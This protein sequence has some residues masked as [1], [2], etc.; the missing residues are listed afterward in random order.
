MFEI[1]IYQNPQE[2]KINFE[3]FENLRKEINERLL[4]YKNQNYNNLKYAKDDKSKL[5]NFLKL[6]EERRK[7]IKN[8]I[9]KPYE[10]FEKLYNI[11]KNDIV[12]VIEKID[13]FI[14]NVEEKEKNEKMQKIKEYFYSKISENINFEKAFNQ[15]WLNKTYPLQ[16]IYKEIDALDQKIANDYLIINNMLSKYGVNENLYQNFIDHYDKT[17]DLN[18]VINEI[19]KYVDLRQKEKSDDKQNK[20]NY[21]ST[22][23]T[24]TNKNYNELFEV[25]LKIKGEK[26]KMLELKKFLEANDFCYEVIKQEK[27]K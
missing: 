25:T 21:I 20:T 1:K 6:L 13:E 22:T 10:E 2:V 4:I 7:E 23:A 14:K 24:I 8:N 19:N 17:L 27:I 5:N 3:N 12:E 15:K 9:M 18:F 11:I 16:E 26:L